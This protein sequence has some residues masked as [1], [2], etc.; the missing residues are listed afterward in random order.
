MT[1]AKF[2]EGLE[3]ANRN[4]M[5]YDFVALNYHRMTVHDLK[6][7]ILEM[8]FAVYYDSGSDAE[9]EFVSNVINEL[10][11]RWMFDEEEEV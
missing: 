6:D 1:T 4:G 10:K 8:I 5:A 7:I 2:L 3:M 9:K 11:D